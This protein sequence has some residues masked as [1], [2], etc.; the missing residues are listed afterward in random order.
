MNVQVQQIIACIALP[1]LCAGC[2]ETD[3]PVNDGFVPF[4]AGEGETARTDGSTDGPDGD[5]ATPDGGTDD[6]GATIVPDGDMGR[7]AGST[8]AVCRPNNDGVITR[9]E[10]PLKTGQFATYKAALDV[11][12]IDVVGQPLPDDPE[13]RL[14][15]LSGAL[16]GDIKVVLEALDPSGRWFSEDFPLATYVAR[17]GASG[18]LLG[19]FSL[20]EDAIT[21]HGFASQQDGLSATDTRYEPGATVLAFPM[22]LGSTWSSDVDVSGRLQGVY[23]S[24][25]AEATYDS[26][27]DARGILRTPFGEFDVLRVRTD[28][29]QTVNFT[30]IVRRISYAFVTECFGTVAVINSMDNE[31]DPE[32]TEAAEVRRLSP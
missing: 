23:W 28:F 26:R 32:F 29:V 24:A 17:L 16:P 27:V 11:D 21:I 1:A 15:D 31:D 8:S 12:G 5:V 25:F 9:A 19:V 7:D 3:T 6:G 18:D 10:I 22:E 2:I 4:D 20:D 30:P 14:W 13:R